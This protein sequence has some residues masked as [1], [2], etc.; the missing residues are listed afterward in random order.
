MG[1][2]PMTNGSP[3]WKDGRVA[4]A[5]LAVLLALVVAGIWWMSVPRSPQAIYRARCTGCH[6]L[7]D[8]ATYGKADMH[9]LIRTMR[10]RNGA[11]AVIGEA[12]AELI[13]DYLERQAV[14]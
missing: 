4:G 8:L 6:V 10:E 3:I 14:P 11:H 9:P 5:G 1:S 7:P 12:D 13:I 2:A